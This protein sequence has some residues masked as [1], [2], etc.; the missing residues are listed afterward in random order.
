MTK[1][2][3]K[4][5]YEQKESRLEEILTKLDNAETPVDQLASEAK[6]AAALITLMN[7]TLKA[8]KQ[9]LTTV[10]EELEKQMAMSTEI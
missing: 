6:E 3:E 8:A 1:E 9:E 4:M 2:F 7:A 10:F 5:T